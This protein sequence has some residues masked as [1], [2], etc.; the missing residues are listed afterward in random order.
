MT[1]LTDFRR[2]LVIGF[3]LALT[4]YLIVAVLCVAMTGV[5]FVVG[6]MVLCDGLNAIWPE[7]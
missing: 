4:G 5:G 3:K 1:S 6:P 7:K 2:G